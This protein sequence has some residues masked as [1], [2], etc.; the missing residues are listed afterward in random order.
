[1]R[2]NK[3]MRFIT[4]IGTIISILSAVIKIYSAVQA[5]RRWD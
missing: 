5:R 4:L 1:M 2:T 3:I